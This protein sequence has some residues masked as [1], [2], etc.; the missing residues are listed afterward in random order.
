MQ[1][2]KGKSAGGWVYSAACFPPL[3]WSEGSVGQLAGKMSSYSAWESC[4]SALPP[5][6]HEMS[7]EQHEILDRRCGDAL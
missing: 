1:H 6:P 7:P 2:H 5:A 3:L 4:F